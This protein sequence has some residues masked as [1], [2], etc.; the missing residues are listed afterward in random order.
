MKTV[1]ET[2]SKYYNLPVETILKPD[3]H[4]PEQ[5]N[6]RGACIYILREQNK[7]FG[8]I[9]KALHLQ[10]RGSVYTEYQR[11][12]D[13]YQNNTYHFKD[14]IDNIMEILKTQMPNTISENATK[15]EINTD[16]QTPEPV[17]VENSPLSEPVIERDIENILR[18]EPQTDILDELDQ[19]DDYQKFELEQ[20][21][22]QPD[23]IP[24]V[25]FKTKPNGNPD[26][27]TLEMDE[28]TADFSADTILNM[29]EFGSVEVAYYYAQVNEREVRELEKEG[30]VPP[31][32]T[33]IAKEFNENA[34]EKL[35]DTASK[36]IKLLEEPLKKVLK[37]RNVSVSPE[38]ALLFA[39]LMFVFSMFMTARS[40]K[41]DSEYFLEKLYKMNTIS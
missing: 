2:V 41:K 33:E 6:A 39:G 22:T 14:Q 1:L 17:S 3:R 23:P 5:M 26:K 25:N 24:E 11:L 38:S 19:L 37:K 36:N 28:N 29:V 13:Y 30:E 31:K 35:E 20:D 27:V 4:V 15:T 32:S 18:T 40:L 8:D 12:K 16:T 34:R 21:A 7:S 10:S 9:A